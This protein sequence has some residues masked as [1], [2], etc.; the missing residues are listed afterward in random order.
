MTAASKLPAHV[1]AQANKASPNLV[2]EIFY[3]I[4]LGIFGGSFWKIHHL[5]ERRKT[6]EFYAR[7]EAGEI[8]VNAE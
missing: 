1:A 5:N 6:E 4:G 8:T 3:G 2:K 7:L